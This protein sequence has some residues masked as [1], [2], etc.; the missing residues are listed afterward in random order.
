MPRLR[1]AL[2]GFSV[3]MYRSLAGSSSDNLPSGKHWMLKRSK[4]FISGSADGMNEKEKK[5]VPSKGTSRGLAGTSAKT[6]ATTP[7]LSRVR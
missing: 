6:C 5:D 1:K 7:G 4:E 3:A 2:A